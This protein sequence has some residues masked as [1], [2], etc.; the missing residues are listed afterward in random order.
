LSSERFFNLLRLRLN[1]LTEPSLMLLWIRIQVTAAVS[2][3]LE[4]SSK[5][6]RKLGLR[7]L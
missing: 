2:E 4:R 6:S 3:S 5:P 1:C 7:E